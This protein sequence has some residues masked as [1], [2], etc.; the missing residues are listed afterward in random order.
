MIFEYLKL[1]ITIT[2]SD[3]DVIYPAWARNY[4]RRHW[5]PLEMVKKASEFL[6]VTSETKVLDVGSGS[7]KFCLAGATFT[8]GHFT[9]VEQRLSLVELAKKLSGKYRIQNTEFIHANITSINFSDYDAFYFFNSFH[10]N[11]DVSAKIDTSVETSEALYYIYNAY[12]NQQLALAPKG[13]RL[14]T[15]WGSKQEVPSSYIMRHSYN[16]GLL[17]CWEKVG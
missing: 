2:D 12:V 16:E 4:S 7:G 10:E 14:V 9:G 15:Y 1:N 13:T 5:T 8:K 11:V 6:V 17:K 3:F